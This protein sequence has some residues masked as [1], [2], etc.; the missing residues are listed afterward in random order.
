MDLARQM[1]PISALEEDI[2]G[3]QIELA[4]SDWLPIRK[5]LSEV[6]I[7]AGTCIYGQH[8]IGDRWLF[9]TRGIAA[10]R[11]SQLDGSTSIARFFEAHQFCANLTSTWTEDYAADDLIAITDVVGVEIPAD[12]CRHQYLRGGAFGEYLRIKVM[13]TLCFDKELLC[14]KTLGDTD[15]RY[16]FLEQHHRAVVGSA[17]QKDIASFLGITPQ[18]LSRFL[19]KRS[20]RT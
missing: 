8:E 9:L 1:T 17:R 5:L 18:G 15:T 7:E 10:S 14:V 2:A 19:K 20:Q 11:Q 4:A 13:D 6:Q 3:T 16:S 12:V